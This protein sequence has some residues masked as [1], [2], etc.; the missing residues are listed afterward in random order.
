MNSPS[1]T[2]VTPSRPDHNG[3]PLGIDQYQSNEVG[4][5][6]QAPARRVRNARDPKA[7]LAATYRPYSRHLQA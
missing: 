6:D 7:D 1:V 4:T 2:D 5:W 3:P